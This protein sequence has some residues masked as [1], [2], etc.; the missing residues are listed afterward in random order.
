MTYFPVFTPNYF[1]MCLNFFEF[2]NGV[3]PESFI[4][5]I[6]WGQTLNLMK[7]K[8]GVFLSK[9]YRIDSWFSVSSGSRKKFFFS[10]LL[11]YIIFTIFEYSVDWSWLTFIRLCKVFVLVVSG[12]FFILKHEWTNMNVENGTHPRTIY[13]FSRLYWC[14]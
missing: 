9:R 11:C 6:Y 4:E 7:Q 5:V 13:S 14:P 8:F 2:I 3:G 1:L 12:A 10:K